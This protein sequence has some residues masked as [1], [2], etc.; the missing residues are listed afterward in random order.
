VFDGNALDTARQIGF[1]VFAFRGRFLVRRQIIPPAPFI[2][3]LVA[4][5]WITLHYIGKHSE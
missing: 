2:Q 3:Y 1:P 5:N 4:V